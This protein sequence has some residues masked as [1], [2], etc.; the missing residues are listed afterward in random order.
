MFVHFVQ[1]RPLLLCDSNEYFRPQLQPSCMFTSRVH[2]MYMYTVR[3]T[4]TFNR[5]LRR[6]QLMYNSSIL[7][8]FIRFLSK[9]YNFP[10]AVVSVV[11]SVLWR[12]VRFLTQEC[13]CVSV[14]WITYFIVIKQNLFTT[15]NVQLITSLSVCTI[16]WW[17]TWYVKLSKWHIVLF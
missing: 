16:L 9:I 14:R 8:F 5:M 2:Y 6:S 11:T 1:I 12:C 15:T 3:F 7:L 10:T 4:C 17:T 13:V